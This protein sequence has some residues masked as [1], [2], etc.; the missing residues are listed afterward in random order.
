MYA[1]TV[2]T[3]GKVRRSRFDSLDEALDA[4][5]ASA[6]ELERDGRA[7]GVGGGLLRRFEPVA[8]VVG[9]VELS[10]PARL[11]AGVDIRGDGS[12]EAFRGRVRRS[13]IAQ[14]DG[15][16]ACDALAREVSPS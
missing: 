4:L 8:Q 15:E 13:L 9:R 14:R 7:G 12:S 16:S 5:R 1:V 2:R 10:G 3:R 11:R 6:G